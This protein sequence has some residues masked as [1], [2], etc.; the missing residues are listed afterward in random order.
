LQKN[1]QSLK[2]SNVIYERA[3]AGWTVTLQVIRSRRPS[4]L[5]SSVRALQTGQIFLQGLLFVDFAEIR[6]IREIFHEIA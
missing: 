2:T 4:P 1:S 3:T 5:S 6:T